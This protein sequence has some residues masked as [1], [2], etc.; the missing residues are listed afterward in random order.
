MDQTRLS[1]FARDFGYECKSIGDSLVRLKR[2]GSPFTLNLESTPA[3]SILPYFYVRSS[4]WDW[5]G[6]RSDMNDVFSTVFSVAMRAA[7]AAS[8]RFVEIGHPVADIPGELYAR[9]LLPEQPF[10][11]GYPGGDSH[12]HDGLRK[13]IAATFNAEE[14]SYFLLRAC[15]Y[16]HNAKGIYEARNHALNEWVG[17]VQ[18][19]LGPRNSG[20]TYNSRTS[21][22]WWYFRATSGAAVVRSD[23]LAM[24]IAVLGSADEGR[25]I[26]QSPGGLL[27]RDQALC[28]YIPA[29]LERKARRILLALNDHSNDEPTFVAL[30]NQVVV[31]AGSHCIFLPSK[32]GRREFDREL[33]NR[34]RKHTAEA[35]FLFHNLQLVWEDYIPGDRFQSLVSDLLS[36]EPGVS[37]VRPAGTAV[38]RDGTRDYLIDWT[39]PLLPGEAAEDKKPPSRFRRV[40]VQCKSNKAPVN[41]AQLT[42]VYDT[43]EHYNSGYLLIVRSR[44]TVPLIDILDG[45]RA[46]GKFAEWWEGSDI[47]KRLKANPD[48]LREYADIVHSV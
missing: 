19:L 16:D 38:E 9:Y 36:R 43:M 32:V 23:D 40:V 24:G 45:I 44:L 15:G 11:T 25:S 39:T 20:G 4:S 26:H 41:R 21:P 3:G 48:V 34:R 10:A 30:E 6:E 13:L 17:R 12:L 27:I 5:P 47:E 42:S 7:L 8:C 2:S 1:A 35:A 22:N 28:N 37:R 14:I 29:T 33:E 18:H 46:K 31:A